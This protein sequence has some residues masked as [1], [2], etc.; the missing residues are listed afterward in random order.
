[1]PQAPPAAGGQAPAVAAAGYYMP[2]R[3]ASVGGVQGGCAMQAMQQG[4]PLAPAT[5]Q[6]PPAPPPGISVGVPV[7]AVV[8]WSVQDMV[9]YMHSLQFGH[10]APAILDNGIDGRFLLQCGQSDLAAIGISPLQMK[11]ITLNLPK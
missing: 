9:A 10:L 8:T 11:K 7:G 1:M 5:P 6:P 2:Q 4:Q 3:H